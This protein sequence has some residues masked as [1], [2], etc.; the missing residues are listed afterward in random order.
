MKVIAVAAGLFFASGVSAQTVSIDVTNCRIPAP[1]SGYEVRV[2]TDLNPFYPEIVDPA[3]FEFPEGAEMISIEIV[4]AENCIPGD[5]N[6]DGRVGLEDAIYILK[7]LVG[8]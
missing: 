3:G 1:P 7:V 4:A 8:D 5:T 2:E 6:Q